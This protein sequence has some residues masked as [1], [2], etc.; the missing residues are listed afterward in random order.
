MQTQEQNWTPGVVEPFSKETLSIIRE[1]GHSTLKEIEQELGEGKGIIFGAANSAIRGPSAIAVVSDGVSGEYGECDPETVGGMIPTYFY[2]DS[3]AAPKKQILKARLET[4][5]QKRVSGI[6]AEAVERFAD[7]SK[8]KIYVEP[9]V[10]EVEL[11]AI[12]KQ[13]DGSYKVE[14]L[15]HQWWKA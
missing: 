6:S 10:V 1:V 11:G 14:V 9:S 15:F 7:G 2:I 5:F 13:D 3:E 12:L 8:G 4:A